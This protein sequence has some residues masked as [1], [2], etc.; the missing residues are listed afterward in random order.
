LELA[1]EVRWEIE[2]KLD[3]RRSKFDF[4]VVSGPEFLNVS[5]AIQDCMRPE[6]VVVATDKPGAIERMRLLYD[7][8]S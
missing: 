5:A 8:F 7:P 4:D 2:D 3:R 1:N 6:R